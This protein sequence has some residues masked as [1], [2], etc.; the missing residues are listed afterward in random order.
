MASG[1][2]IECLIVR[3]L[4]NLVGREVLLESYFGNYGTIKIEEKL[5]E[6]SQDIDSSLLFRRIE[7]NFHLR[8]YN[9]VQSILGNIQL[10]LIEYLRKKVE[11]ELNNNV[12]MSIIENEINSFENYIIPPKL[13]KI[14]NKNPDNYV[15]LIESNEEFIDFKNQ[16]L[17]RQSVK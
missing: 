17:E 12:D 6:L 3:N 7:D 13:L 15:G 1:Y 16:I 11:K 4:I 5:S 8:D 9:C 2:Y 10:T 14:I